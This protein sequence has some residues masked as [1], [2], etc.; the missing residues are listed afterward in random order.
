MQT[1]RLGIFGRSGTGK[2]TLAKSLIKPLSIER[3][4]VF[5]PHNEYGFDPKKQTAKENL[6]LK[7]VSGINPL[8]AALSR[9][10]DAG[11]TFRFRY[12]PHS[13]YRVDALNKVSAVINRMQDIPDPRP[14]WFLVDEIHL[15]YGLH[16]KLKCLNFGEVNTGGRKKNIHVIGCSQRVSWVGMDFR[17]QLTDSCVFHLND[18]IDVKAGALLGYP[19]ETIENLPL[20][21]YLTKKDG[22][23]VQKKTTR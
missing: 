16:D 9:A 11:D 10:W 6:K 23:I 8:I 5:D 14:L 19:A 3:L 17:S 1:M 13:A 12:V 2:S 20:H 21:Q 4:I 7:Q 15:G 22:K 18:A